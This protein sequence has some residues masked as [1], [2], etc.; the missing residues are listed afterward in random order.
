MK[1]NMTGKEEIVMHKPIKVYFKNVIFDDDNPNQMSSEQEAGLD[2]MLS[3]FGFLENTIVAPKNAD[4]K[5]LIHHGEH[6]IRRLMAAGNTWAWGVE[7]N[8]TDVEHRLLRQG[9]NKLHGTHDSEK[10]AAEYT[11]LQKEGSLQLLSILIAQPVEQLMVEKD[12]PETVTKD[13]EL[14]QHHKDT[15]LEGTLK[16]LYFIFDNETY[17][18]LM[19]RIELIIKHMKVDTNQD[20]FIKLVESYEENYLKE[21]N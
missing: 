13:T 12:L 4:G 9:M 20:M 1:N 2:E 7:K 11:V 18:D 17:E 14:I 6:R 15:F 5:Q 8:L 3:K 21:E 16:Q 19:P 10:D